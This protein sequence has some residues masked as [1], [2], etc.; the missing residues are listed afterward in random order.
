MTLIAA[1]R[2]GD[3]VWIAQDSR[4]VVASIHGEGYG[5]TVEKSYDHGDGLVWA[6]YGDGATDWK[7]FRNFV[8][9]TTFTSW[10]DLAERCN[11]VRA[12]CAGDKTFGAVF[13][14]RLAGESGARHVGEPTE[15]MCTVDGLFAATGRLSTRVGWE[16]SSL[17]PAI[18]EKP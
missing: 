18:H 8:Q 11:P 2:D 5:L 9:D 4:H 7:R 1:V 17:A 12:K 6:W 13:A 16:L 10:A 15:V 3:T 14:G